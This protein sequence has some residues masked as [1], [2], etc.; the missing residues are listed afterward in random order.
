MASS[1]GAAAEGLL[2]CVYEGCIAGCD[3]EIERRPYHRNCGC[4]LHDKSR[5]GSSNAALISK[6]CKK[7]VSYPIRR[8]WSEGSLLLHA[9]SNSSNHSSPS[10]SPAHVV[11]AAAGKP[12]NNHH[13]SSLCD[14]NE[15]Q[16]EYVLFKI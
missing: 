10:S 5:K 1:A 11:G 2:R 14:R 7:N 12:A 13:Q 9:A 15:D 16:D 4:A 8:S 6:C 3:T